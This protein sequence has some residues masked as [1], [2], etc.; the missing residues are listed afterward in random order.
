MTFWNLPVIHSDIGGSLIG[1][2]ATLMPASILILCDGV[3]V[4]VLSPLS[5]PNK[6]YNG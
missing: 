2:Y 6:I 5:I 4:I 3:V 1:L